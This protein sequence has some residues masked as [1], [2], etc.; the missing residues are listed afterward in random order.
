[1]KETHFNAKKILSGVLVA[2]T[3]LTASMNTIT[4]VAEASSIGSYPKAE[5]PN[6]NSE[7]S[8]KYAMIA[9]FTDKTK[10][11]YLSAK[12]K[13]KTLTTAS[14]NKMPAF[15]GLTSSDCGKDIAKYTNVG[16]W[17]GKSVDVI[18]KLES[19]KK[20]GFKG[21]EWL[22]FNNKGIGLAQGG[23]KEVKVTQRFV[24]HDTG[25]NADIT[26]SYMTFNDIDAHQAIGFSDSTMN[27]VDKIYI[28]EKAKN[29]IDVTKKGSM[30]YF[31]S[32]SGDEINTN[33][34]K[35]KMTMLFSGNEITYSFVKDWAGYDLGATIDY[36]KSECDQYYGYIGEK[37]VPTETLK[38]AKLVSD[39]NEKDKTSNTL[40]QIG[41][42]YNYTVSHSVP[43]EEKQFYYKSYVLEDKLVDELE[44][45]KDSVKITDSD[46]KDVTAK[47]DNQ[48]KGNDLKVS[49]KESTLKSDNFYGKDYKVNFKVTIKAG[50][51]LEKYKDKE[52]NYIIPN[53]AS[54]TKDGK[55]QDTNK[56]TTKLTPVKE[57]ILKFI[58]DDGKAVDTDTLSKEDPVVTYRIDNVVSNDKFLKSLVL[59]DD[60]D[61]SLELI[62][63]SVKVYMSDAKANKVTVEKNTED[64]S[65]ENSNNS[66][67]EQS[68]TSQSQATTE[69]TT[70]KAKSS[71]IDSALKSAQ[72]IVDK[73]KDA[74]EGTVE[75]VVKN[76][77]EMVVNALESLKA[78]STVSIDEYIKI[79]EGALK[80]NAEANTPTGE[81][82]QAL[83]T[84]K[85]ILESVKGETANS[86]SESTTGKEEASTTEES[87]TETITD[88][89]EADNVDDSVIQ[90]DAKEEMTGEATPKGTDVTNKGKLEIKD[91]NKIVWTA[92]NPQEFAGKKLTLV[93]QAKLKDGVKISDLKDG[94]IPNTAVMTTNGT[95]KKSNTVYVDVTPEKETV[96]IPESSE[97]T[98]SE[99]KESITP[100]T[101]TSESIEGEAKPKSIPKTPSFLPQT[102][103]DAMKEVGIGVAGIGLGGILGFF[104]GKK[105][106]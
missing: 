101:S 89:A 44:I 20:A 105:K 93:F 56:T 82:K 70:E 60:V 97:P 90:S 86:S 58:I 83:E 76:N 34:P 1:M 91:G 16:L 87:T 14:G 74:K 98:S 17:K 53:T 94:K 12:S 71:D 54:V 33:D 50:S 29:W 40:D 61:D 18:Y 10:L 19:L 66:G 2:G 5:V 22:A 31:G 32:P 81:N 41:E 102:G 3:L 39:A 72:S 65:E 24:Y 85:S 88:N 38:P 96:K 42:E 6:K 84:L 104:L 103:T 99:P 69:S 37:P 64:S 8:N 4:S 30:T 25:K 100:E 43:D 13:L 78:G 77:A 49:A 68:S 92:N 7:A 21:G 75:H 51:S 55:K 80:P 28:D 26:G 47:F 95:D 57:E 45:V 9:K 48:T 15:V 36:S 59:T 73:Y 67:A 106:K 23:Y 52:G 79:I 62:K 35:G 11:E 46:G 27:R 63:D